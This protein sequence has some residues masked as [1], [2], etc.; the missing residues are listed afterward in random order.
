MGADFPLFRI[1]GGELRIT[2][3]LRALQL[4]LSCGYCSLLYLVVTL[5]YF[6]LWLLQLTLSCCYSTLLYLVV[7]VAY[8]ILLLL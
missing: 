1:N 4:T 6:I 2:F 5:P 3:E 7:T 8:S